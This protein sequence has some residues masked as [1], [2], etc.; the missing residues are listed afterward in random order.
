MSVAEIKRAAAALAP[1]EQ[2]ELATW[3]LNQVPGDLI[4]PPKP[5]P[6]SQ[7]IPASNLPTKEV[8]RFIVLSATGQKFDAVAA[9]EESRTER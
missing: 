7:P 8:G 5:F 9:L 1:A 2:V 6:P 3:L 4:E